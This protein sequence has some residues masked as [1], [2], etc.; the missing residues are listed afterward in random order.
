M[1]PAQER[2][3][4]FL[5]DQR[6]FFDHLVTEDWSTYQS[7][8]WDETRRREV[9]AVLGHAPARRVLDVGCGCGFHDVEIA[10]WPGVEEVLGIDY[11]PRSIETAEREFPHMRVRRRVADIFDLQ[12]DPFDLVVS[13]Q[14]I[15]HVTSA[16]DCLRACAR[17]VKPGGVVA[18]VT[19]NGA[20]LDNRMRR[21]RGKPPELLDP[22]HFRE[23][24][25]RELHELAA[26]LPLE[27]L[28][29]IGLSA[30]FTVPRLGRQVIPSR[31]GQLIASCFPSLSSSFVQLWRSPR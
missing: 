10:E 20:R 2:Y 30:T 16:V 17:N 12:E 19:P 21:L 18:V 31:A 8:A 29:T 22:Q 13:F 6:E 23:Y 5:A 7:A 25:P 1:S 28:A 4:E 24:T 11:S 15:E 14:V 9:A 3:P 27:P 26:E